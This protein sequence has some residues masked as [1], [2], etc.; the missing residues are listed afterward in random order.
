MIPV[1][2]NATLRIIKNKTEKVA[3]YQIEITKFIS[4]NLIDSELEIASTS[5][6]PAPL[7][8]R[9]FKFK[10]C[11]QNTKKPGESPG[12]ATRLVKKNRKI[13]N[14][15]D[16]EDLPTMNMLKFTSSNED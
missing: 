14:D 13:S 16:D 1:K 3:E 4:E 2:V 10:C 6:K 15:D 5:G 7:I 11:L 8:V 12:S 9:D